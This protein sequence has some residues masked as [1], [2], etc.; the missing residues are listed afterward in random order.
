MNEKTMDDAPNFRF[1]SPCCDYCTFFNENETSCN[2]YPSAN[3]P[4]YYAAGAMMI[5][6]DY[7]EEDEATS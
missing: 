4:M 2:K 6:D 1:V 5:C 7:E 3:Y